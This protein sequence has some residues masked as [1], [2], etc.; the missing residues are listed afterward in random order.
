MDQPTDDNFQT[1]KLGTG[2]P[3]GAVEKQDVVFVDQEKGLL[4][5]QAFPKEVG[6]EV[7]DYLTKLEQE[8]IQLPQPVTDDHTGQPILQNATPSQVTV[9]LPFTQNEYDQ[10]LHVKLIYSLRWLAEQARRLVK[11]INNKFIYRFK[12]SS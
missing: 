4:E 1:S 5:E 2:K 12:I 11:L 10:A 3:A 7:K 9:T 6:P 8:E